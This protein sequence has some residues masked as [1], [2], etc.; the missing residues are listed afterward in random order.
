MAV[1]TYRCDVSGNLADRLEVSGLLELG[2][3]VEIISSSLTS[4]LYVIATYGTLD[5][6]NGKPAVLN[7]PDGFSLVTSLPAAYAAA[8]GVDR[9]SIA[10]VRDTSAP[11]ITI[12]GPDPLILEC[13]IDSYTE[14]GATALDIYDGDVSSSILI[15][16]SQVD[17][18]VPG[19]YAVTYQVADRFGNT[20]TATR[21]VVVVDNTPPVLALLGSNPLTVEHGVGA[22]S[23]PGATAIDNC[24]G[25]LSNS[26]VID[27][28]QVDPDV[29]GTYLVSYQV[30]DGSGNTG[31]TQ[32][33]V[34]VVDTTAPLLTLIGFRYLTLE[35]G[36]PYIELGAAAT[37]DH[38]GDLTSSIIIDSS[39]VDPAVPGNYLVSY[40]VTD[41]F[42]NTIMTHRSVKVVDTTA[43]VITLTGANPQTVEGGEAYIE[44]G[45][46]AGDICDGDLTGS[47]VIDASAVDPSTPGNYPVTYDVTDAAGNAATVARTVN[48]VDTIAPV[49]TLNGASTVNLVRGAAY[50]ELGAT[51][52]DV[53]D[54]G[55]VVVIGGDVVNTLTPGVYL[56]TYN[57]TDASGNVA[58]EVTRTVT[59]RDPYTDWVDSFFPG[60]TDPAIIGFDADPNNDGVSNGLAFVTGT[61]PLVFEPEATGIM[62]QVQPN[63]IRATFQV[64]PD[65]AYLNP[66][67]EISF[68]LETWLSPDSVPTG[69]S[70]LATA[71]QGV[72]DSLIQVDRSIHPRFFFRQTYDDPTTP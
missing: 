14:A 10:L 19:S 42:G 21:T 32:R 17:P 62:E 48:V 33:T 20:A 50:T 35:C 7:V 13:G 65:A 3:T 49:I 29:P 15:D 41:S 24:D 43:P 66:R 4:D 23:D 30:T 44:L 57:A 34:E 25:D 38:D 51:V 40:Q 9:K 54:P 61:S 37:D 71:S 53:G 1:G 6:L 22:Y 12:I 56:V 18:A 60:E 31:T 52:A 39:Q 8:R 59:V 67:I 64:N 45:A 26:I 69:V 16:S 72:F 28:S 68:N 70:S 47:I 5:L 58:S 63:H 55:T 27:S 2:G 46:T 11:I 36:D